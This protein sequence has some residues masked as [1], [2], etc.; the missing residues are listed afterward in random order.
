M[1]YP[2]MRVPIA[3]ALGWPERIGS[4]VAELDIIDIGRLDFERPDVARFPCLELARQAVRQ[5]GVAMAQLNAANEVAV[6]A[7]LD[8]RL[9]FTDIPKLIENVLGRAESAEPTSLD[10][11]KQADLHARELAAELLASA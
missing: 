11:V 1:G 5:G 2:H 3:H 8:R 10:V 7:F 6:D 9:G 4:G